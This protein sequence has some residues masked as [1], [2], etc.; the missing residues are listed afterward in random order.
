[1]KLNLAVPL[2]PVILSSLRNDFEQEIAEAL[3][4]IKAVHEP[5]A[6]RSPQTALATASSSALP[7]FEKERSFLQE[8][9]RFI[10]RDLQLSIKHR[11]HQEAGRQFLVHHPAG[12]LQLSLAGGSSNSSSQIPSS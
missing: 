2:R 11:Q 1:M 12:R 3:G 4:H 6:A 9:T 8:P 7:D 10:G 5:P